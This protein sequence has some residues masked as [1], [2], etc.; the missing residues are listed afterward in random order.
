MNGRTIEIKAGDGRPLIREIRNIAPGSDV[1]ESLSSCG[2]FPKADL[3]LV[4]V[5]EIIS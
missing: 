3:H 4:F 5:D 2:L 1:V